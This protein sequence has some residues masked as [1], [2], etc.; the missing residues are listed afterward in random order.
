MK[1]RK[2]EELLTRPHEQKESHTKNKVEIKHNLQHI[3]K[4][5]VNIIPGVIRHTSC[6]N[7]HLAFYLKYN[8]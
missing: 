7:S 8:K 1:I 2:E 5:K 4:R 3:E 6:P